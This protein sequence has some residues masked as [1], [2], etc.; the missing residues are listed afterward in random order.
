MGTS[1]ELNTSDGH[2]LGAYKATPDGSPRA[3]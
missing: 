3:E 1:I 2:T